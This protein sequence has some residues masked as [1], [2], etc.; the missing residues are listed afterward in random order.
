ML[1]CFI[2]KKSLTSGTKTIPIHFVFTSEFETWVQKQKPF[3]QHWLAASNFKAESYS[4]CL[5]PDDEGHLAQIYV[6]AKEI[7]DFWVLGNLAYGL[8]SGIYKLNHDD[9]AIIKNAVIS[10]ALGAYRFNQYKKE[11]I[12]PAQL[13]L[14]ELPI[15]QEAQQLIHATYLVRDLI[16][17]PTEY[18]GPA[19]L[20]EAVIHLGR[21]FSADV[22]QIV[23]EDL[24][25]HNYPAIHAV[26][27]ASS[28]PPRLIDLRWGEN[29]N[30]K[31]TLVGK[32]V[33]F[34]SGGLDL[35]STAGMALMKKD[36]G[37]AAHVLGLAYMIMA[38]QLP[39]NL[40]VLIPAVENVVSGN[41]YRPGDI[42]LTRKGLHVEIGN[43]D[44]EGRLILADALTEAVTEKPDFL[45]DF[46]TLTGAARVALGP[47]LPALFCNEERISADL[48]AKSKQEQ[49]PLWSLPLYQPYREYLDSPFADINNN[50]SNAYGGA[51]AAA[52]FLQ[53]FV[54][55]DQ[56]WGHID[57]MAWNMSDRPGRPQG[58]EA[59]GLRAVWAYLRERYQ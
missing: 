32:G 7:N 31:L 58:G 28:N 54:G 59:M 12:A 25:Q 48:L 50:S 23:G 14:S 19:Q 30:P 34:D 55:P 3:I 44:A 22:S 36:M 39:V 2:T 40:R 53:E 45:I 46:A 10:W 42:I 35:K 56:A 5:L 16:N 8:P 18:M 11:A 27:R 15:E 49:D 6:G 1:P 9:P 37:G 13:L 52:L 38:T 29:T 47:D 33:C 17:T 57:L 24:I 20:A 41:A 43:T 4:F 51:I 21:Q 26:G